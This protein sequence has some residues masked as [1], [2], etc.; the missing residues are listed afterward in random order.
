MKQNL[1]DASSKLTTFKVS[2]PNF[3][4][5]AESLN[6]CEVSWNIKEIKVEAVLNTLD[7][8]DFLNSF[9]TFKPEDNYITIYLEDAKPDPKTKKNGIM[10]RKF[11]ITDISEIKDDNTNNKTH[12][13][14]LIDSVSYLLKNTFYSKGY[15]NVYFSDVVNDI[16]TTFKIKDLLPTNAEIVINKSKDERKN[17]VIPQNKSLYEFLMYQADQ[18][19]CIIYQDKGGFYMKHITDLYVKNLNKIDTTKTYKQNVSDTFY[20]YRVIDVIS[21]FNNNYNNLE[22]PRTT[23]YVYD[24]SN[25]TVFRKKENFDELYSDINFTKSEEKYIQNTTG[26]YFDIA[27]VNLSDYALVKNTYLNYLNNNITNIVSPG[28]ITGNILLEQRDIFIVGDTTETDGHIKGNETLNGN[29]IVTKISDKILMN[30]YIQN[31]NFCRINNSDKTS[32]KG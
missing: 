32:I 14:R 25:K 3:V 18:E 1:F 2:L 24:P 12:E 16:L 23:T 6:E 13:I 4:I 31:L 22:F 10:E 9:K 5:P 15:S 29:Y 27:E 30:K 17:F 11:V 8:L 19:G 20:P 7:R 21:N 26:N 28:S